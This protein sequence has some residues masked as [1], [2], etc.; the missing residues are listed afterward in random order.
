LLITHPV[1]GLTLVDFKTTKVKPG[2]KFSPYKTWC[3]QLAAYRRAL[4]Q[5]VR[6]L[7]LVINSLAPSA[8]MEHVWSEEDVA[9]GWAAFEAARQ[10]WCIE[11]NY[12]PAALPLA[13]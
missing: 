1:H 3:Y 12:D 11:K 2:T 8:P 4:G 13:A 6:C 5:P 7:N 9:R 10:L